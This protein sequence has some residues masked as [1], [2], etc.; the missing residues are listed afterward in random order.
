MFAPALSEESDPLCFSFLDERR[1]DVDPM[2][3]ES[4][5]SDLTV[6][7]VRTSSSPR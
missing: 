6:N 2:S 3:D 1:S 4:L 7:D 5:F